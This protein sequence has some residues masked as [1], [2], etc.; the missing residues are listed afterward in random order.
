[1]SR[2]NKSLESTIGALV[3]HCIRPQNLLSSISS[4]PAVYLRAFIFLTAAFPIE[5]DP[6]FSESLSLISLGAYS[7][8]IFCQ[9][10]VSFFIFLYQIQYTYLREI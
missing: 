4:H 5:K 7:L 8:S 9:K 3:R 2:E 6:N 10:L 1:M